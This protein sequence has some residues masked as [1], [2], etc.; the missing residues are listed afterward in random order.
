MLA[1]G[2]FI[3]EKWEVL[4]YQVSKAICW[5]QNYVNQE[6][7]NQRKEKASKIPHKK[8][9]NSSALWPNFKGN[10][11]QDSVTDIIKLFSLCSLTAETAPRHFCLA[12]VR[13]L[14]PS[15]E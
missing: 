12:N 13:S 5:D 15:I 10:L 7:K 9:L 8:P 11:S 14:I 6:K 1:H 3:P 4:F 2:Q